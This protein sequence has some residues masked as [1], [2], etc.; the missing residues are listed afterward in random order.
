VVG[1]F[2]PELAFDQPVGRDTTIFSF[3]NGVLLKPLPQPDGHR[4][5]LLQ[6][7]ANGPLTDEIAPT[8]TGRA[9]ARFQGGGNR[10]S[11]AIY[12]RRSS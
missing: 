1:K 9:D 4:L 3:V 11:I 8:P 7:R 5:V 12:T 6:R 10:V 2:G